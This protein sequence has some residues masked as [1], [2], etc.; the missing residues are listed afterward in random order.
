MKTYIFLIFVILFIGAG[1]WLGSKKSKEN[2][3]ESLPLFPR[4]FKIIGF[5]WTL[6][7]LGLI[8]YS[9]TQHEEI[10]KI[11][12]NYSAN[13]GLVFICFSK[14]KI[15]DELTNSIRLRS[16]YT[17][18]IAGFIVLV[19]LNFA[20]FMLGDE[21]SDYPARQLVTVILATY[22]FGYASLKRKVRS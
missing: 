13:L 12:F 22:A 21:I 20:N 8:A 9:D 4:Y 18:V 15:E 17:S 14:D 10:W 16:F 7:S 6:V 3:S 11:I 5:I 19:I 1:I 2:I